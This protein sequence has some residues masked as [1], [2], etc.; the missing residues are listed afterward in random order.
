MTGRA[1]QTISVLGLLLLAA[2]GHAATPLFVWNASASVPIGIYRISMASVVRG[3]LVLIRLPP[4]VATLA[5]RRGYLAATRTLIKPAAAVAGDRVCRFGVHVFVRGLHAAD[6]RWQD[7]HH[8]LMPVWQGCRQLTS[9]AIF[10]LAPT[11][12]SFDSRYFGPLDAE[13][14]IGRAHPVWIVHNRL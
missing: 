14:V 6:A 13:H 12:Q 10:L 9:S 11:T 7:Q 5:Q 8:R 4:R 2:S 1:I 3:D